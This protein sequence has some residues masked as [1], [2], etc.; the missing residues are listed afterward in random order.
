MSTNNGDWYDL[1]NEIGSFLVSRLGDYRIM[2]EKE[3]VAIPTWLLPDNEE[4]EVNTLSEAEIENLR[5]KWLNTLDNMKVAFENILN[6][7]A[8]DPSVQRGLDLF[9]KYY[10][11]LW[12]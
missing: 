8:T 4:H 6:G 9:A 5:A 3:G 12:D 11:H 10:I 7:K 1:K 2:F